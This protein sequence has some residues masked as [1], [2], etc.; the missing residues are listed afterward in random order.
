[1]ERKH[2][3]RPLSPPKKPMPEARGPI[4]AWSGAWSNGDGPRRAEARGPRARSAK[5]ETAKRETEKRE[6]AKRETEKRETEKRETE[7]RNAEKR[8]AEK[9]NAEKR[10][11][12]SGTKNGVSEGVALGYRVIQ[13]YLRQGERVARSFWNP[14]EEATDRYDPA[15]LMDRAL[16]SAQDLAGAFS[17]MM[18]VL[19][20]KAPPSADGGT[21]GG[22]DLEAPRRTNANGRRHAT[23]TERD[24]SGS[25]RLRPTPIV[26]LAV[27]SRR[28]VKVALQLDQG[29]ARG[30]FQIPP[31]ERSGA[32]GARL[33]G[34][35]IAAGPGGQGVTINLEVPPRLAT[36]RYQGR[37]LD[38]RTS[39]PVGFLNV[40]VGT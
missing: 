17:E 7:K 32:G 19:A 30:V 4:R 12:E 37:V 23:E 36:G 10:N 16:R 26:A 9:R 1:M 15:R 29:A 22:F 8:N 40:D 28:P 25:D 2:A 18:R 34:V 14:G 13:E 31:L 24:R 5:R 6:T 33:R 21:P 38:A 11:A 20:S 3:R 27:R 39:R 35:S